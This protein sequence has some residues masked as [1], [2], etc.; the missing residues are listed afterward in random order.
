MI[1]LAFVAMACSGDLYAQSVTQAPSHAEEQLRWTT[2][3]S[4]SG[5]TASK[6]E[7][8]N[9]A[10]RYLNLKFENTSGADA[11]F[12]WELKD[13]SGKTIASSARLSLSAGAS[14]SGFDDATLNGGNMNILLGKDQSSEGFTIRINK[15]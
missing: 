11:V 12:A 8:V 15:L 2:V 9:G 5:I 4:S 13:K 3:T 10:H 6:V 14:L 1:G 7:V